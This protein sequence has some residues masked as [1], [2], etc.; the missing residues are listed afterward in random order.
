M[1]LVCLALAALVSSTAPALAQMPGGNIV[2]AS[3]AVKPVVVKPGGAGVLLI[4]LGVSPGYHINAPKPNDPD[5]IPTAFQGTA[6]AGV[7]FGTPR[8]PAP[9]AISVSYEKQP[10]LVYTG[11]TI[12]QVPF[13]IA[14]TVK[15]GRVTLSGTLSFQGCNATSCFPPASAA[16][17]ALVIVK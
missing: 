6:S 1:R 9:K 15:P 13:T 5:L 2:K 16:V 4:S 3:A 7:T 8:F 17:K 10:M 11:R 14:R 12:V